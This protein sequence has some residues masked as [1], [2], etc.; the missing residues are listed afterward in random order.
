M[1]MTIILII[2]TI[3]TRMFDALVIPCGV[4]P[5][6]VFQR[7]VDNAFGIATTSGAVIGILVVI[8]AGPVQNRLA[9]VTS[10][11]IAAAVWCGITRISMALTRRAK[12]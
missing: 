6:L 2:T 11:A 10:T 3:L 9:Y 5:A 4:I 1:M 12:D 7:R 8:Y